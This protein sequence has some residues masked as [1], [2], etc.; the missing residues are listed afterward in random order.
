MTNTNQPLA[1]KESERIFWVIQTVFGFI[2]GRSFFDYGSDFLPPLHGDLWTISLAL[3]SVYACV[4]WSWIDFSFTTLTSP[5][6]FRQNI[7]EKWRFVTDL[8][9]V[10]IYT[11]LLIY[12]QVLRTDPSASIQ[13]FLI[14]YIVVFALYSVSGLLRILEHGRHASRLVLILSFTCV[15]IIICVA[16]WWFAAIPGSNRIHSNR[17]FLIATFFATVAYRLIRWKAYKRQYTIAIDVDGVLADQITSLLPHIK[18]TYGIQ[19]DYNAITDW[20]LPVSDTSIDKIIVEEQGQRDYVLNMPLHPDAEEMTKLLHRKHY[21][22]IATARAPKTDVWTKQWLKNNG[23]Q[24][25]SYHNLKEGE[26]Q[27]AS[28]EFDLLIDDYSGNISKFLER[29]TGKAILFQQPWNRERKN[30]N[31]FIEADRLRVVASW[32]EIPAVVAELLKRN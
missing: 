25:D 17:I 28:E 4:L 10:L 31:S 30:L 20:R 7:R 1:E 16:Y 14:A 21:V 13:G 19:L 15:F 6:H 27:N 18:K 9:I 22:A 2:L 12:P 23:I 32:K 29:G 8:T 26:K 24:Y 5:Y 11:Y 3:L